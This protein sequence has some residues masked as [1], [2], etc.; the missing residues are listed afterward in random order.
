MTL[1]LKSE[2]L[3]CSFHLLCGHICERRVG[4]D[5]ERNFPRDKHSDTTDLKRKL[6]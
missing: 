2:K 5:F 6:K 1:K 4:L 3:F